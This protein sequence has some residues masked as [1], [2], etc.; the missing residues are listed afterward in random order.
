VQTL[1]YNPWQNRRQVAMN[2]GVVFGQKPQL[3]WDIPAG[4]SFKLLK[5][6]YNVPDE[7][8]RYTFNEAVERLE[9]EDLL[10]TP[11]RLLSLGQRM[12]CDLAASLIHAPAVAFLDEPTIGMDVLVKERVRDFMLDMRKKFG[13]TILLTTHDLKDISTTSERLLVLDK[14][15]LLYDGS[16]K[17]FETKYARER[18]IEAE[19]AVAPRKATVLAVEKDLKALGAKAEWADGLL[20]KVSCGKPQTAPKVTGV[21]LKRLNVLDL[22]LHGADIESIVTRLYRKSTV[23]S[24]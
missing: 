24:K 1:G 3:L 16:L 20:L 11:V 7:V 12:R 23:K 8:Y 14:G 22:T 9:L 15:K 5:S 4:E 13:T 17:G 6:L 21:L 19:L 18:R 10:K 2:I